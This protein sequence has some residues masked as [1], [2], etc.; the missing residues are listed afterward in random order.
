MYKLENPGGE[1]RVPKFAIA[2]I[3]LLVAGIIVLGVLIGSQQPA[4]SIQAGYGEFDIATEELTH[5]G[6]LAVGANNVTLYVP[7]A[8]IRLTGSIIIFP[9][10]PNLFPNAGEPGWSRP[11][12]VNVEYR[13]ENGV[14]YSDATFSIPVDICF[15]IT[16]ARWS[17]YL[18]RPD[19]YQVQHYAEDQNPPRWEPLPLAPYPERNELC[20]KTYH[21]SLFALA[22]KEG[23]TNPFTGSDPQTTQGL[24]EP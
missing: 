16:R 13:D 14:P 2:F 9:R 10:E 12:V 17:D 5:D 20:G 11:L 24:Y 22:I 6:N 1:P 15:K 4:S 18:L 19:E 21:L 3:V 7:R 23:A 8:A